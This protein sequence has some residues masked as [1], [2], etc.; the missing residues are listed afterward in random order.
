MVHGLG[1]G[2]VRC[3][4]DNNPDADECGNNFTK[5]IGT[6]KRWIFKR[7]VV[8]GESR[9][10]MI[11]TIKFNTQGN[12]RRDEL[13]KMEADLDSANRPEWLA[14]EFPKERED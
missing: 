2:D 11:D 12:G 6:L 7:L 5:H 13:A 8:T 14:S 4:S 10:Q 3:T 9:K 1:R